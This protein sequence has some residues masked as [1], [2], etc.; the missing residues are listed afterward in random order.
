[1]LPRAR[2]ARIEAMVH[3]ESVRDIRRAR[4]LGLEVAVIDVQGLGCQVVAVGRGAHDY[5]DRVSLR[6]GSRCLCE[7]GRKPYPTPLPLPPG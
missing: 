4:W 7:A 6:I 1:M 2:R 5:A 3:P